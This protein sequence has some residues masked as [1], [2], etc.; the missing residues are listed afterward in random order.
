VGA[1][2][3]FLDLSLE[4]GMINNILMHIDAWLYTFGPSAAVNLAIGG[5]LLLLAAACLLA[6]WRLE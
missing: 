2:A 3:L 1:A 4:V 5:V 6:A